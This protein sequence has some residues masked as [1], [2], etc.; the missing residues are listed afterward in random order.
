M[1]CVVQ[2]WSSI[3]KT[4]H[5]KRAPDYFTLMV[6]GLNLSHVHRSHALT[7][8]REVV[9]S[10]SIIVFIYLLVCMGRDFASVD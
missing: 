1:P 6:M 4:S 9:D 10:L 7:L 2:V 5:S 3:T 8:T